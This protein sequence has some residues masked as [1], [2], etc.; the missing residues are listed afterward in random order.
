[1]GEAGKRKKESLFRKLTL[2]SLH[3]TPFQGPPS[4]A[5]LPLTALRHLIGA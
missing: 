2:H 1:M 4:L 3:S 5:F